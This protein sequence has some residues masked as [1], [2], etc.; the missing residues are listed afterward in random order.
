M[1]IKT[2]NVNVNFKSKAW[3]TWKN[4]ADLF[5]KLQIFYKQKNIFILRRLKLIIHN[6]I[7]L[8]IITRDVLYCNKDKYYIREFGYEELVALG[9]VHALDATTKAVIQ[10]IYSSEV[11]FNKPFVCEVHDAEIVGAAPI[12]FDREGNIISDTSIALF[13][14]EIGNLEKILPVRTLALKKLTRPSAIQ[15]DTACLLAH[16][17]NKM[18]FHWIADCLTRIEGLEAYQQQTGIKPALII[19]SNL[20]SWQVDSLKLLGYDPDNCIHWNGSRMQVKKL[21]V[22]SFRRHWDY[23]NNKTY[24]TYGPLVSPMACRWVCQRVLSSLSDTGS[25]Q[26]SFSSKIFI[27]RRKALRRRIL[28]ENEVIEALAPL[29]FVAYML[30]EMSFSEQVR[31]FSQA[32]MVVAPHG[33]GLTN[34]IFSQNLAVIELF[35]SF[36]AGPSLALFANLSRGL[37]FRYGCLKGQSPVQG[38]PKL[39]TDIIV[40]VAEL[41]N[42]IAKMQEELPTIDEW[43]SDVA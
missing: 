27:S 38:L 26:L 30:E 13:S 31:L 42:L 15:L 6:N 4:L 19:E 41:Q 5:A 37:G 39:H 10:T 14:N 40:D 35:G 32:N 36:V 28:N 11:S 29:G 21:V 16:P 8:K 33:S 23:Y 22:P 24:K 43:M 12:G 7:G 2:S 9:E 34:M 18:Y 20:T 3:N 17:F 1:A 25:E